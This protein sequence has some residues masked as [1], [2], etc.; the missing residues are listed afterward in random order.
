MFDIAVFTLSQLLSAGMTRRAVDTAIRSGS[1]IRARRGCY[2][3]G[4][5]PRAVVE[6]VRV[7][8]RLTCLSMLQLCRVFVFANSATHV[9]LARGA[10]RLRS[11]V[12]ARRGLEPPQA[13]TARLHW[14]PLVRPEMA[15]KAC[16]GVIDAVAHAVLCQPARYAVATI[17]SAL[18][19]GL[20]RERELAE[21]FAA[22]P[23]K[24]GVLRGLID[25][26]AQSG[27]E[28][29]VRLMARALGCRV[30]IQVHFAGV[31]HVDLVLDGWLVVECDS[32]EFHELVEQQLEDR[33][34]DGE[35]A[36]QGMVVLRLMAAQILYRPDEVIAAL[37]AVLAVHRRCAVAAR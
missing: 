35:L 3:P 12:D 25:G 33:R 19:R 22:L 26:R 20:L 27:T 4:D 5:A 11:P 2:L 21:L 32:R 17:D 9:H 37:R 13:R 8:G 24:Y 15:G 30:E 16:V 34:R 6:A 31:G 23:R 10:S 1:L 18:N 14:L 28:T 36:K 29:L 7:G